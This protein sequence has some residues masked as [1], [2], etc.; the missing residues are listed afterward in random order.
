MKKINDRILACV[1]C[2]LLLTACGSR[3]SKAEPGDAPAPAAAPAGAVSPG[4]EGTADDREEDPFVTDGGSEVR[5]RKMTLQF[6]F[7]EK[8]G[9]YTGALDADGLPTGKGTFI[10]RN[11]DGTEWT[12]E[13]EFEHGHF[14]GEGRTVWEDGDFERGTYV[15][16]VVQPIDDSLIPDVYDS[17]EEFIGY[18]VAV[19]GQ[20]YNILDEVGIQMVRDTRSGDHDTI[21]VC[22]PSGIRPG[23]FVKVT[24]RVLG[25]YNYQNSE[26]TALLL[27]ASNVEPAGRQESG[28]AQDAPGDI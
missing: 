28:T 8:T 23:D 26:L 17:P 5:D 9:S 2:I 1:L 6:S 13:G 21:I 14:Q 4:Q 11:A 20:V 18:T 7:G 10:S 12:Y 22:N 25:T 19:S 3:N 15:N 27:V 24:G 16:D